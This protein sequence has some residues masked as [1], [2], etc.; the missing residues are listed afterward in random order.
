MISQHLPRWIF[1]SITSHFATAATTAGLQAF[2]EGEVKQDY[3]ADHLEIRVNGP[4]L[5]EVSKGVWRVESGVSIFASAAMNDTNFHRIH[6]MVGIIAASY[7]DIGILRLGPVTDP[8]INDGSLVGCLKC[9]PIKIQHFGQLS[10]V[11]QLMRATIDAEYFGLL[12]E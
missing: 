5:S 8:V 9:G 7:T 10:P 11:R 4:F 12:T 3:D 2:V 1:A 6:E